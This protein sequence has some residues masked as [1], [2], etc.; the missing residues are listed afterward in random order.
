M[1]VP[2]ANETDVLH[3]TLRRP[4]AHGRVTVVHRWWRY[5]RPR[6]SIAMALQTRV[7]AVFGPA[8]ERACL[9]LLRL[10]GGGEAEQEAESEVAGMGGD[11]ALALET[12][13]RASTGRTLV[14]PGEDIVVAGARLRAVLGY[15]MRQSGGKVDTG[16]LLGEY[17]EGLP[18][19]EVRWL[20]SGLLHRVLYDSM[21]EFGG[22]ND[23]AFSETAAHGDHAVESLV[24]SLCAGPTKFVEA[25]DDV[26]TGAEELRLV[27]AA[28]TLHLLRPF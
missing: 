24:S 3:L 12:F 22:G 27:G 20:K 1:P 23:K 14:D 13:R 28:A 19:G 2:D 16:A 15:A 25:L 17:S 18:A 10:M 7:V 26:V 5:R 8:Y 11:D 4:D 9:A 21:L 6:P